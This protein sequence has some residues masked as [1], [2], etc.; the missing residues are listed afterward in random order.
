MIGKSGL[1]NSTQILYHCVHFRLGA[2]CV[3]A[4]ASF[5]TNGV[6]NLIFGCHVKGWGEIL[7][8]HELVRESVEWR[9]SDSRHHR[10]NSLPLIRQSH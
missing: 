7:G 6:F 3:V 4:P 8:F 10:G 1:R 9:V 2:R 5:V